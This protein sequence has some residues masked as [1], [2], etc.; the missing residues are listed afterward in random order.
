LAGSNQTLVYWSVHKQT[1]KSNVEK[2]SWE[3]KYLIHN[4]NNIKGLNNFEKLSWEAN[5][6]I[7]NFNKIKGLNNFEKLSW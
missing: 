5:Y 7:Q 6:I 3:A 4:F 1:Q 2:L